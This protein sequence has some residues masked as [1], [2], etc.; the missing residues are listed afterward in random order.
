MAFNAVEDLSLSSDDDEEVDAAEC[1]QEISLDGTLS[2]W[3]N[4]LHGWQD[5]YF[6][7]RDGN[8]SYY[9]SE[10]DTAYGCRGSVSLGKAKI[11][12]RTSARWKG[13]GR[14]L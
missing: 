2:K 4:Y 1:R 9:K 10:F 13:F 11:V 8:F 14:K 6:I 3:T 5:R 7:L 12:V